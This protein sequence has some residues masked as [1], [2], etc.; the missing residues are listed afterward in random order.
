MLNNC[1][2]NRSSPPEQ[3]SKDATGRPA[4]LQFAWANTAAGAT[5]LLLYPPD[6]RR[7]YCW[8][9]ALASQEIE[10]AVTQTGH[11]SWVV[12]VPS[13]HAQAALAELREYERVNRDWPPAPHSR[14]I[15]TEWA[16][17]D[18]G[19]ALLTAS[20][21]ILVLVAWHLYTGPA[22]GTKELLG[23]GAA[24]AGAIRKGAIW[25]CF[26]A[27]TL[28]AD[29]GHVFGNAVSLFFFGYFTCRK[30]G[31]GLGWLTILLAGAI[32]NYANG[33]LATPPHVAIGA[34]T[35][36]FATIGLLAVYQFCE[37]YHLQPD[38]R[39][40]W[41]RGWVA[42]LAALALL[43]LLGVGAGSDI[44]GHLAGFGCGLAMGFL[45]LKITRFNNLTW[46][47]ATAYGT[48]WVIILG[49][50]RLALRS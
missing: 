26:T 3:Q 43:A 42:I 23:E 4:A 31:A 41:H 1:P 12:R 33:W 11:N 28:H 38:L 32:G 9:S 22:S 21:T 25:R 2:S 48:F 5:E 35:A 40:V 29:F 24:A 7:G 19:T 47:N 20:I 13:T 15:D 17:A 50:W 16:D 27:L 18:R 49:S 39:S 34:S 44:S 46:L 30:A 6:S 45:S 37:K 14:T 8:L 36:G 10:Y